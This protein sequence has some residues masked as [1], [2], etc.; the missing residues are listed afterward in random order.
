[1]RIFTVSATIEYKAE[2]T[3]YDEI[4]IEVYTRNIRRASFELLF[5]FMNHKTNTVVAVGSQKL[6]FIDPEN[7]IMPIPEEFKAKGYAYLVSEASGHVKRDR[8]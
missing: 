1:M 8:S 5:Y 4:E 2:L 6:V 7:R 3:L